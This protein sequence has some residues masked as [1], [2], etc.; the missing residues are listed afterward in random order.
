MLLPHPGGGSEGLAVVTANTLV[1]SGIWVEIDTDVEDVV[2]VA[3][4]ELT[5]AMSVDVVDDDGAV[6]AG[7]N[8]TA[9]DCG[10][11]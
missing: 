10:V 1:G 7:V 9:G 8:T 4:D 3:V 2:N 5:M 11:P 6:V